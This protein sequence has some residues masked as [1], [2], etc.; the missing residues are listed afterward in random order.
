M[1]NIISLTHKSLEANFS[2]KKANLLQEIIKNNDKNKEENLLYVRNFFFSQSSLPQLPHLR[3]IQH[4]SYL[5]SKKDCSKT[6]NLIIK[7]I[8][9]KR[10][11]LRKIILGINKE[12]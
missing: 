7:K 12:K 6:K 10:D 8:E 2:D 1:S 5:K 11:A 9:N 4:I 3:K